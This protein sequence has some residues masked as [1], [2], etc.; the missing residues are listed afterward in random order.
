[1]IRHLTSKDKVQLKKLIKIA[2]KE[3]MYIVKKKKHFFGYFI[4]NKLVGIVGYYVLQNEKMIGFVH[5]YTLPEHRLKGI[6]RELSEYRLQ[7]CKENYKGY[8]VFVTANNKSKHQLE[9][10]GFQ[11]IEPQYRMELLLN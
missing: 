10:D 3:K 8:S 4:D 1:M 11:I 9:I 2:S 7:Y 6:Y 5:G